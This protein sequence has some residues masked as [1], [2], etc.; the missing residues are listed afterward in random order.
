[1]AQRGKG[2]AAS[3]MTIVGV[4]AEVEFGIATNDWFISG[5]LIVLPALVL[6]FGLL[7][8]AR[9]ALF[10]TIAT[11]IFTF[12]AVWRSPAIMASGFTGTVGWWMTLFTIVMFAT[13]LLMWLGQDGIRRVFTDLRAREKELA[14]TIRVAPY[15]IL[16]VD[17]YDLVLMAN[18]A[19]EA[20][21]RLSAPLMVGQPITT[22]IAEATRINVDAPYPSDSGATPIA[23]QWTTRDGVSVH[24][25]SIWRRMEG[26]RRQVLLRDVS[27]Q[28]RA[29]EARRAL[30]AQ[31]AQSQRLEAVGQLAGGLAHD[32][33]NILTAVS[34]LAELL[35]DEPDA[36]M[37]HSMA[38][39]LVASRDRGAALT[40]QLL[41]FARREV[42]Q[43]RTLDLSALVVSLE[44]RLQRLLGPSK[45]LTVEAEPLCWVTLDPG[46]IEQALANLVTNAAESMRDGGHCAIAVERRGTTTPSLVR[47]RVTDDGAG[48]D[49]EIAN[50]AFEPFFTTKGRGQGTGLG[51]AAV[52]AMVTQ[53]GGTARIH[54]NVGRGTVVELE[55][56]GADTPV[57]TA[58][59]AGITATAPL[60]VTILVA[61]DDDGT[62]KAVAR[63]LRRA[64]YTLVETRD[65]AE[66]LREIEV[67][68]DAFHLLLTDV[69][70]PGL[71]GPALAERARSIVPNLPVL[72]MTG[73]AEQDVSVHLDTVRRDRD[74]ITK[75]FAPRELTQRIERLL[76]MGQ[77]ASLPQ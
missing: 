10:A 22:V 19:A 4:W 50:R 6:A 64:G 73:Y 60:G 71:T 55:L 61:E 77:D 36:A 29:E 44:S 27:E 17:E 20:I 66:A 37:R 38:D 32:F 72:F 35:R 30:E 12:G 53:A 52:H 54:S 45:R 28:Y 48:M 39:E 76:S 16:V 21:L 70:M 41:A 3:I 43:P 13:W 74:L 18:P 42:L 25:E 67:R 14:D 40:R 69:M 26:G 56:P 7:A 68:G 47:L 46:Q 58:P 57:V 1:M 63:I 23:L 51:L 15:G 59:V 11:V 31:T 34:G 8:G 62:R 24:V 49:A 2:Y 9:A 75:P 65:G 33:N 5:G